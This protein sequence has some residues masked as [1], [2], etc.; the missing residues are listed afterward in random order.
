MQNLVSSKRPQTSCC[1]GQ[2]P[3]W[4]ILNWAFPAAAAL[5]LIRTSTTADSGWTAAC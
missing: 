4:K 2:S 1:R 5:G 3:N